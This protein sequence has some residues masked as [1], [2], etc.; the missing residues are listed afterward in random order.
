MF[1]IKNGSIPVIWLKFEARTGKLTVAFIPSI[2]NII[3]K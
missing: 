3:E 2:S 1:L